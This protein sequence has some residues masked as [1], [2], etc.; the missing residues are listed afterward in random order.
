MIKKLSHGNYSSSSLPSDVLVYRTRGEEHF[1][2]NHEMVEVS[3]VKI[4]SPIGQ[5][6]KGVINPVR[7]VD[8]VKVKKM[9][10]TPSVELGDGAGDID[11]IIAVQVIIRARR[12]RRRVA[13]FKKVE[14]EALAKAQAKAVEKREA[15][16][17]ESAA[18]IIQVGW[19]G[20]A[21]DTL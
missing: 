12:A 3:T 9:G 11:K 18:N 19:Q 15:A 16:E 2:R 7:G 8:Q 10:A 20:W 17:R 5:I 13:E 14:A 21:L 1:Q 4:S 6:S